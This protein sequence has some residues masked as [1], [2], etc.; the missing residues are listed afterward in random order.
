MSAD[1]FPSM[2][3]QLRGLSV[4]LDKVDEFKAQTLVGMINRTAFAVL[5]DDTRPIL[6]GVLWRI[7]PTGMKLVATDGHRFASY[8]CTLNLSAQV[9]ATSEAIV[10]PQALGQ[11][12]KLLGAGQPLIKIIIGESQ[13]LFDLGD[14]QLLSRLIEGPYVDYDQV[15]PKD[16][17]RELLLTSQRFLP[18]VRRVSILSSSY[19]HQIRLQISRN[20]VELSAANPEIGGEARERVPAVYDEEEMEVGYNA[21]Y[22]MEI[23]R[24]IDAEQVLFQLKNPTTAAVLRPVEQVE[25]EEYFCLLMPLRPSG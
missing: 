5:K 20:V 2:P 21:Q 25:G 19:T 12:V 16:N 6:N 24:K 3:S 22:L 18:A 4:E 8:H 10:P 1:D 14:T 23:L 9:E 11:V 15:I 13:V 17:D 7:D